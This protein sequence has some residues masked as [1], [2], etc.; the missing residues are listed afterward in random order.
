M[1]SV[2]AGVRALCGDKYSGKLRDKASA[3]LHAENLLLG[4]QLH[5][6]S[7]AQKYRAEIQWKNT[8]EESTAC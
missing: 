8:V 3:A 4:I 1:H 2:P 7:T 5:H 6:H